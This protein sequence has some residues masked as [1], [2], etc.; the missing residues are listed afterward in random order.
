MSLDFIELRSTL[1]L[2]HPLIPFQQSPYVDHTWI[3]QAYQQ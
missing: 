1:T 2:A 3:V